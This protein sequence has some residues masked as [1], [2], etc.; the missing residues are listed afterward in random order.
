MKSISEWSVP[1]DVADILS[2][3]GL[4]SYYQIFIKGFSKISYPIT[5]LQ[6]KG[7]NFI[8]SPKFQENFEN[9]KKLV[10]M[11]LILKVVDPYKYYIVC[12]NA[13]KEGLGGVLS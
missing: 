12:R 6:K 2:F 9:I 1:K 4:T 7:V 10:T 5:L 3:M 13:I 11:T 8:W